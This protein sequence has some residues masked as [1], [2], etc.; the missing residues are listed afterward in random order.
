MRV[1]EVGLGSDV[2][3]YVYENMPKVLHGRT[4]A[5]AFGITYPSIPTDVLKAV[6]YHTTAAEHMAGLEMVIYIADALEPG[7]KYEEKDR[8]LDMVGKS[9][10]H[11][12][13]VE[14]YK[15]SIIAVLLAGKTLHPDTAKIWNT[16][17]AK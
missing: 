13:F 6:A 17:L 15:Y 8:L 4:A 2:D 5:Y 10:L 3:P 7:R 11:E 14:V 9:S 12:L 1:D 16:H